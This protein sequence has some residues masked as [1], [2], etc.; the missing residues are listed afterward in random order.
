VNKVWA[1][2]KRWGAA[3]AGLLLALLGAGWMWKRK[4]AEIA[5]LKDQAA[6]DR[7]LKDMEGLRAVR[8][9]VAKEEGTT[10]AQI[11]VIDESLAENRRKIVEAHEGMENLKDDEVEEAFHR[12]GF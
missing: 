8:E 10:A 1:F 7:A 6:V 12:L 2:L 9:R 3:L 4:Q 11:T 5:R